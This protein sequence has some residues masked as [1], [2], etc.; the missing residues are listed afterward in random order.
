MQ[1]SRRRT[2]RF[3]AFPREPAFSFFLCFFF[4]LYVFQCL[5][6]G[7]EV[8]TSWENSR[9]TRTSAPGDGADDVVEPP[10]NKRRRL[11]SAS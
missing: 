4:T 11:V 2:V 9:S 7:S 3:P 1:R 5:D 8:K 6:L 10:A